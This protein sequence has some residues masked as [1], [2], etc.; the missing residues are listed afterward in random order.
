[1]IIKNKCMGKQLNKIKENTS[2]DAH[3]KKKPASIKK[4][5]QSYL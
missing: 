3:T 2:R 5:L 1:M 4:M